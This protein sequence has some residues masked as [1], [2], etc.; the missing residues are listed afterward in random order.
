MGPISLE[1]A[2]L[3]ERQTRLVKENVPIFTQTERL[4]FTNC[5][6]VCTIKLFDLNYQ[7]PSVGDLFLINLGR[8]D[9]FK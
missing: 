4:Y 9:K 7:N 1:T 6:T 2:N 3:I 8:I 5:K